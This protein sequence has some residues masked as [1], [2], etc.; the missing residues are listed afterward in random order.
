MRSVSCGRKPLSP[1]HALR[2]NIGPRVQRHV[3]RAAAVGLLLAL[4]ACAADRS[5]QNSAQYQ[6]SFGDRAPTY[7]AEVRPP[8]VETEAD[9]LPVQPPPLRR[10]SS[11]DDPREPWS[12]NYGSAT[13]SR[14]DLATAP[15]AAPP[16]PEP[17]KIV[18]AVRPQWAS[19]FGPKPIAADD[20]IRRAIAE[21]EMRKED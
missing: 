12:P 6:H 5:A 4:T 16:A 8:R 13:P 15:V 19:L 18:A 2:P 17:A 21:H 20:I 9:G 1:S 11:A 14:T 7:S 10:T 3:E